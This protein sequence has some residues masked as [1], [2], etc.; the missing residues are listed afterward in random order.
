MLAR[1]R[2]RNRIGVSLS[3]HRGPPSIRFGCPGPR[4]SRG[5]GRVSDEWSCGPSYLLPMSVGPRPRDA[6]R[7]GGP[8]VR[9]VA[10]YLRTKTS[11]G[12][13]PIRVGARRLPRQAWMPAPGDLLR[14][15]CALSK[16]E[17]RES[18][19][20]LVVRFA[21]GCHPGPAARRDC[22]SSAARGAWRRCSRYRRGPIRPGHAPAL[23][24]RLRAC[25]RSSAASDEHDDERHG[26]DGDRA[27]ARLTRNG[28]RLASLGTPTKG[29]GAAAASRRRHTPA[30][31]WRA[32]VATGVDGG[33]R[34]KKTRATV[35]A[36]HLD[37]RLP[38]TH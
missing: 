12:T 33:P 1:R 8:Y 35:S 25:S 32:P 34:T 24:A 30:A 19:T 22:T 5:R 23:L 36:G 21:P 31:C 9:A 17:R 28:V 20:P 26:D 15:G 16:E 6:N 18:R 13:L 7:V 11:R 2:L 29:F 4:R 14:Q 3:G 37:V 10:A 38:D 27:A